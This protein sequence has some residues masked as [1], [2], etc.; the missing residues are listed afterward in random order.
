MRQFVNLAALAFHLY[1][2][3]VIY[4]ESIDK[5]TT[6]AM[7]V[8][9]WRI[10]TAWNATAGGNDGYS[11]MLV[12]N[13]RPIRIDILL[14]AVFLLMA[15][16][17]LYAVALGP[18]DRWIWIYW[19]QLDICFHWWTWAQLSAT[20]PML[21]ML[22]CLLTNLREQNSIATC[23]VLTISFV[24]CNALTELWSRPHRNADRSYDMNRWTG[25]E[26]AV[27]PGEP[28]TRL[29]PEE[30]CQRA[31]QQSRRRMNYV[32]R[33]LPT[34][35]SIIPFVTAWVII[36]NNFFM[37]LEDLRVDPTDEIYKRTPV[38]VPIAVIGTL[39]FSAGFLFPLIWWQWV[40][41]QH[42]WKKDI[43]Y[44]ILSFGTTF[45]LGHLVYRHVLM[46][47][48]FNVALALDQNT[49]A[50]A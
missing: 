17:H 28:W 46:K 23:F 44:T 3:V 4:M 43:A 41:P 42:Y 30:M 14:N 34:V 21:A 18:F 37:Q 49:T 40:A 33:L 24:G 27:K 10:Q 6:T 1:Y 39:V 16:W 31:M 19:R 48:S 29:S 45:F 47:D 7:E 22:V 11:A 32:A 20:L 5:P 26:I 12:D 9:I 38:F 8:T 15:I 50:V 35:L 25:D 36:L 2:T 13:K